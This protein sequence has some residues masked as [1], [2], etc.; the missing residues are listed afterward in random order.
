MYLWNGFSE[1]KLKGNKL[2]RPRKQETLVERTGSRQLVS[3][4]V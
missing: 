2:L 3:S 1:S 4:I